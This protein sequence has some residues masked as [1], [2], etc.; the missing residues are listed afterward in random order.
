[1]KT[2]LVVPAVIAAK[3]WLRRNATALIVIALV[4]F[5]TLGVGIAQ[6]LYSTQALEASAS[7]SRVHIAV[8][9]DQSERHHP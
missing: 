3:P 1:M 5:T 8:M 2:Y 4:G 7:E 9:L 6:V